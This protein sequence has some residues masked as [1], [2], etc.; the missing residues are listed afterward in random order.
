MKRRIITWGSSSEGTGGGR[1]RHQVPPPVAET[2]EGSPA[3]NQP[4][5]NP[6]R[7]PSHYVGM[8]LHPPGF[9]EP[10]LPTVSRI[11]PTAPQWASRSSTTG[12][13]SSACATATFSGRRQ[14]RRALTEGS[15]P[16]RKRH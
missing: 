7:R 14:P 11:V 9:I 12:S 1:K 16:T 6:A 15:G 8:S 2:R 3:D 10:C 4:I 13:G 5:W